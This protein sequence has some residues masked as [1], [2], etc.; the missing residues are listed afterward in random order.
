[1]TRLLVLLFLLSCGDREEAAEEP[2]PTAAE[3]PT[4]P[5]S[6]PLHVT[7][8]APDGDLAIVPH[9]MVTFDQPMIAVSTQ[10]QA[11]STVPVRLEP[12]PPGRWRWLGTQTLQ[13]DPDGRSGEP[14]GRLPASTAYTVTVPAGTK[15]ATGGTLAEAV[16]F[17]F[18]TP[19]V[20]VT[21]LSP[22]SG[23]QDLHP[24]V[25]ITFD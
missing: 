7:R 17:S 11:S 10:A 1:M 22:Q 16:S 14:E 5:P 12:Q 24:I 18:R 2:V 13:F 6:G 21:Q 19:T 8:H 9:V 25:A 20:N 15:S 4:P 3:R 23:P